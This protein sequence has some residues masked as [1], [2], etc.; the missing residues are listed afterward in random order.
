MTLKG[1][2]FIRRYLMHVLPKRFVKI[3]HYGIFAGRNR[4]TKLALC[5]RLM[6]MIPSKK[7]SEYSTLE[8]LSKFMNYDFSKCPKCSSSDYKPIASFE[9]EKTDS[10]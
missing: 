5:Q 1:T 9:A 8:F 10:S 3:R 6:N 2:E 7:S 4:P